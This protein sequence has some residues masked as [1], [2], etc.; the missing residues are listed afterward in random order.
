MPPAHGSRPFTVCVNL[1]AIHHC[2]LRKEVCTQLA[3]EIAAFLLH[4]EARNVPVQRPN[5]M[6]KYGLIMRHM[7]MTAMMV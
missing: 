1:L 7:G 4:L 3:D 2:R 5:S 6:N